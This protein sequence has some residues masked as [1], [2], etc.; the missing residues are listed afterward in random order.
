M[1]RLA[2]W[3][4]ISA[5]FSSLRFQKVEFQAYS[6]TPS[7]SDGV[8]LQLGLEYKYLMRT[9]FFLSTFFLFLC[10]LSDLHISSFGLF[11]CWLNMFFLIYVIR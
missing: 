3:A 10:L 6:T 9:F 7:I 8:H 1:G 2:E 4:Q 11:L 5:E